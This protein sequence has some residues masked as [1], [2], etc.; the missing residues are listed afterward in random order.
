[1]SKTLNR[2]LNRSKMS[3]SY[4]AGA[5]QDGA[6]NPSGL[7]PGGPIHQGIKTY[8]IALM[9][10]TSGLRASELCMLNWGDLVVEEGRYTAYFTAKGGSVRAGTLQCCDLSCSYLFPSPVPTRAKSTRL[11]LL[12]AGKL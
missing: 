6:E 3:L 5:D 4:Q 8:A 12:Y 11:F 10:V 7:A 1:M 2:K 9:L